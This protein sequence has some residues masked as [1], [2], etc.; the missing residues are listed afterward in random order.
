MGCCGQKRVALR[1]QNKQPSVRH[2]SSASKSIPIIRENVP[3]KYL[4]SRAVTIKGAVTTRRYT[5]RII[6]D[7][8]YVDHRDAAS[9]MAEPLME[10][11]KEK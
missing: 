7:I 2:N 1:Q 4:G 3:F 5:F 9:I 10:K 8:V 11:V 6:G